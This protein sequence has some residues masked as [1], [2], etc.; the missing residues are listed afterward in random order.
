MEHSNTKYIYIYLCGSIAKG[1]EASKYS[2]DK[3]TVESLR[4]AIEKQIPDKKVMFLDP[5]DRGDDISDSKSVVGRDLYS[6][7]IAH[8]VVADLREKRGIG[9]GAEMMFAKMKGVNVIAWLRRDSNYHQWKTSVLNVPLENWIHPFVQELS[10]SVCFDFVE[11]AK[12]IQKTT[13]T[14]GEGYIKKCIN[15]YIFECFPSDVP[16][17]NA[18]ANYFTP[19]WEQA[20]SKYTLAASLMQR[21]RKH[22][23][24]LTNLVDEKCNLKKPVSEMTEEEKKDYN[25][26]KG[27]LAKAETLMI[28]ANSIIDSSSKTDRDSFMNVQARNKNATN[29]FELITKKDSGETQI[30]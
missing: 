23:E 9:V 2:W 10:D 19:G 4:D 5:S 15:H 26:L 14:K 6:V 21:Y 7:E 8:F 20:D 11:I 17:K 18:L 12:S 22:V 13:E 16:M 30:L 1:H 27:M 3:E 29:V 25:K 28:E 24:K